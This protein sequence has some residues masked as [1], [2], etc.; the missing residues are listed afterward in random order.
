M[1]TTGCSSAAE[2][3][4]QPQ[5]DLFNAMGRWNKDDIFTKD[6]LLIPMNETCV[7]AAHVRAHS[8]TPPLPLL[9]LPRA[10]PL[11]TRFACRLFLAGLAG[12]VALVPRHRRFPAQLVDTL[13]S[14]QGE[15]RARTFPAT[16]TE[17]AGASRLMP[18]GARTCSGRS[19]RLLAPFHR[20]RRTRSQLPTWT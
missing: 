12:Q 17:Y 15:R 19:R 11:G 7:A 6:F 2:V 3:R 1:R 20:R 4:R 8:G 16:L 18:R 5:Q 10:L 9:N 14:G 13:A